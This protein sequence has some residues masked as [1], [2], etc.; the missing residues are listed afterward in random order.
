[1]KLNL[2][3]FAVL[4]ICA[5]TTVN[6]KHLTRSNFATLDEENK[7]TLDLKDQQTMLRIEESSESR[8]EI[9]E[10]T[11]KHKLNMHIP[12]KTEKKVIIR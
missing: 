5:L 10:Q 8:I 4:I 9:I 3:L 7:K 2:I 1:M 6:F 12:K 11:A